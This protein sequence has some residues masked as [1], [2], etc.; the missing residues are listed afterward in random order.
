LI[1]YRPGKPQP[2]R[3]GSAAASALILALLLPN[4]LH[5]AYAAAGAI[6]A[7]AVVKHSFGGLGTN[8]L[9]PAAG[10]WLFVRFSWPEAF[11]QALETPPLPGIAGPG[12]PADTAVRSFLNRTV[13]TLTGAELPRGYIDL[14][15]NSSGGIIAD[16]GIAALLLGTIAIAALGV[17]RFWAPALFLGV[18][19]RLARI[20]G[21]LPQGGGWGQGDILLGLCSGG[22]LAAAFLLAGDPV[23]GAKSRAGAALVTAASA[24]L[25]FLFRYPGGEPHGAFLAIPL[26]NALV[27]LVREFEGRQFYGKRRTA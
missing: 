10:G 25:A 23:T 15:I 20:F 4:R 13:F 8:W 2:L 27:P 16:R 26:I 3:D 14:F 17:G 5:P 21:A 19:A 1:G 9:N 11:R 12:S 18:Y 24:L 7:M 6:F 22:T